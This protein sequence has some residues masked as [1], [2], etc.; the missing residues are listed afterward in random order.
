MKRWLRFAGIVALAPVAL[1]AMVGT[2]LAYPEPFFA[3][4]VARGHLALYSD[5][6]FDAGKARAIL[7]H[8]DARLRASPL[9]TDEPDAIFVANAA[10]RQRL[11]MNIAYGAG[12]VNFYPITRNV[13]LRSAHIDADR[14]FG[15]TGK[16][17]APPRTFTYYAAHEITHS[18]T[19]EHLGF[20][21]LWN[22]RLPQWVREGY[23]DYVGMGSC[24]DVDAL[25]RQYRAHDRKM[26]FAKSGYYAKFRLMVAFF[27]RREHWSVDRLLD[28]RLPEADA[29][30]L[31][32]A[33]L[34]RNI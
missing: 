34:S 7:A 10:W 5:E 32:N 12:G 28:S 16:P 27:L 15:P 29:E 13:F 17:A 24:D 8:V 9:D 18:M 14:L 25:Y 6:P 11:F 21:H 1:V 20:A 26:D 31:M 2:A 33:S 4:H 30:R 3:Y 23:A 22:L 19:A